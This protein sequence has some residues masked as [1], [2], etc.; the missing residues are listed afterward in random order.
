MEIYTQPSRVDNL[1]V[2]PFAYCV[3]N[4]LCNK[5]KVKAQRYKLHIAVNR[6]E[7][8][9]GQDMVRGLTMHRQTKALLGENIKSI[10]VA[11]QP[12]TR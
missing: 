7:A 12:I 11:M 1:H 3:T 2:V 9:A 4:I 10:I 8:I 5:H 6:A